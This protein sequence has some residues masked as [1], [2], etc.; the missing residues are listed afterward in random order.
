MAAML[1]GLE[2]EPGYDSLTLQ[3]AWVLCARPVIGQFGQL[4]DGH[5]G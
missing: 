4:S 2:L 5:L 1:K 3:L